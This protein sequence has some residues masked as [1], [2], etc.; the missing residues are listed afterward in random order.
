MAKGKY[1]QEKPKERLNL[2]R[3]LN[4]FCLPRG[5]VVRLYSSPHGNYIDIRNT[6]YGHPTK[7][8]IKLMLPEYLEMVQKLKNSID[9]ILEEE[10]AEIQAI[11]TQVQEEL[12]QEV[13]GQ[14]IN[15]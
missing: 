12:P 15:N 2:R 5:Q 13:N 3:K 4:H 10:D 7:Y 1:Y 14:E 11:E 8:G 6:S 9:K